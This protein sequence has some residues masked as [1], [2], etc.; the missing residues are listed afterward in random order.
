MKEFNL[1]WFTQTNI[2]TRRILSSDNTKFSNRKLTIDLTRYLKLFEEN[3]LWERKKYRSEYSDTFN[4]E[5][6]SKINQ[7]K[8]HFYSKLEPYSNWHSYENVISDFINID[9]IEKSKIAS[10]GIR[11]AFQIAVIEVKYTS[12]NE[13]LPYLTYANEKDI[14]A[15]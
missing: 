9:Q 8:I 15:V 14:D 7:I 5:D 3:K 4:Q 6:L 12:E 2:D 13:M 10:S 11:E 1:F